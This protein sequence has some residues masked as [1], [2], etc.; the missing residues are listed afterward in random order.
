[1]RNIDPHRYHHDDMQTTRKAESIRLDV[2]RNVTI[3]MWLCGERGI[4]KGTRAFV[5]R[6]DDAILLKPITAGY[7]R[8]LRGSLKGS[9]LLK[10]LMDG[11]NRERELN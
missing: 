1:M 11:R 6:E 4:E 3:P 2:K 10:S 9:G 8:K 5:C 7:I